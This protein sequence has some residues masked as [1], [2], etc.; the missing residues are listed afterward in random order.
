[1]EPENTTGSSTGTVT[2]DSV[3]VDAIANAATRRAPLGDIADEAY[4]KY[5]KN[6]SKTTENNDL[7]DDKPVNTENETSKNE[8]ESGGGESHSESQ[9]SGS[10]SEPEGYYA[11]EGLEDE[12]ITPETPVTKPE[13]PTNYSAEEQYI[14][15]NIGR[16]INVRIKVGDQIQTVQAY[17]VDNLPDNFEFPSEKDRT[18]A[19]LGF[20]SIIRKAEQLQRDYQQNQQ[21]TQAQQ[22]EDRENRDIQRDIGYL[23]RQKDQGKDGLDL[24]K[25][26][27]DDDRFD[28]D[29]A[30]KE[31]QEVL[32][33]YNKENQAR[34]ENSQRN[35]SLYNRLSFRDAFR[36]YRQDNPKVGKKQEIEDKQ[37]TDVTRTLAKGNRSQGSSS[38]QQRPKL[39]RNASIDEIA[40]AY[41]L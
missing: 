29:P 30:V 34:F 7:T 3:V 19:Q 23:Q 32:D 40:R 25:Y 28:S 4:D 36:L 1:M 12:E 26:T 5:E 17:S 39:R 35:G 24:F 18:Q 37:R 31:M 27:P 11:D 14:A 22:Y 2:N 15:Q 6:G 13:L 9:A 38:G 8:T 41:G 16:P 10:K 33:Y 20:D 21:T